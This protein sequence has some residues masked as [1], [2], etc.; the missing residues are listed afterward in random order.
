MPIGALIDHAGARPTCSSPATTVRPSPAGPVVAAAALAALDV[1]DDE[2]LPAAGAG[3]RGHGS[4]RGWRPC[5]GVR[6]VRGLGL[7]LAVDVDD[8]PELVRRALLEQRLVLNATGPTTLRFLPPLIV[9]ERR[10]RRGARAAA[11]AA[12]RA[13]GLTPARTVP[14]PADDP[15]AVRRRTVGHGRPTTTWIA[16]HPPCRLRL[17]LPVSHPVVHRQPRRGHLRR[18][19]GPVDPRPRRVLPRVARTAVVVT[20]FIGIVGILVTAHHRCRHGAAHERGL[21]RAA[22]LVAGRRGPR[23]P[24]RRSGARRA[25]A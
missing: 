13:P 12:G 4:P 8:A 16:A 18:A 20:L 10:R 14:S 15:V 24:G 7:M 5:P 11:R 23:A 2:A 17:F 22:R 9:G 1:I 3:A 19:L 6:E 25:P 21:G